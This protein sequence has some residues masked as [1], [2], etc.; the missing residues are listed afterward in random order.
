M[1]RKASVVGLDVAAIA[2]YKQLHADVWPT[3]LKQISS[4]NIRNYS[5]FLKE[6]ENLLF[7]YFEYHGTDFHADMAKMAADPETQRW[8][9]VCMPLQR[10]LD[11]RKDGEWW[12]E[13]E[14]VFHHE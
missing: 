14:E 6:P 7:S 12:A 3:V 5:I 1:D 9:D 10:P 2:E 4:C 8:W 11:T 13:M